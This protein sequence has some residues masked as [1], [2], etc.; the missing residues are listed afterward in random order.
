MVV[1]H[2]H[3]DVPSQTVVNERTGEPVLLTQPYRYGSSVSRVDISLEKVRGRWDVR[4][5]TAQAISTAGYPEDPQVLDAVR[6]EHETTVGYVNQ[7]VAQS[8]EE[9]RAETSWYEDTPILD[10]IQQVQTKTVTA[11]MAGTEREGLPVLSIAAPFSRTAVFPQGDVTIRDI[12]GL[13]VFDNTL[14]AVELTGAQV[15]DY[16]E[17][18][19]RFFEQVPGAG[20]IDPAALRT[21]KPDYNFD[22][23]SG[24]DYQLDISRPAGSRVTGLSVD[25]VPVA[26]DQ[27]FV[28][29]V[30][31][32]RRSGG[33]GFPHIAGAPVV[34]NEQREIRQLLID[35]AQESG[36]IDPAEFSVP[37]WSLVRTGTP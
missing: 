26:D 21:T 19:A 28:V 30:N 36:V 3:L 18:T 17:E 25:G 10:F 33:G 5:T 9:L 16:L 12:A 8:S 15:R 31:N 13:Y 24:V 4:G 27:R 29:A 7:V 32:Y 1:G 2:T 11:A 14:E 37:N 6:E 34:Y 35:W 22:Q 23:L 20:P